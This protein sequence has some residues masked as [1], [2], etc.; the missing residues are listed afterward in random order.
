MPTTGH[1]LRSSVADLAQP[2]CPWDDVE[3]VDEL[4]SMLDDQADKLAKLKRQCAAL[5]QRVKV[6]SAFLMHHAHIPAQVGMPCRRFTHALAWQDTEDAV[7]DAGGSGGAQSAQQVK[8][9]A[10][11]ASQS[12]RTTLAAQM[13]YKASLKRE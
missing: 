6:R 5:K 7:D 4:K 13:A 11:Q 9:Q 2:V 1:L 12:L 10:A 8:Q 3:D